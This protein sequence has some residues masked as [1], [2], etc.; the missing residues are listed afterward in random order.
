M[1]SSPGAGLIRR[2]RACQPLDNPRSDAKNRT[3][4]FHPAEAV[5]GDFGH[6]CSPPGPTGNSRNMRRAAARHQAGERGRGLRETERWP[7]AAAPQ[8][9]KK[10]GNLGLRWPEASGRPVGTALVRWP[11]W[12]KWFCCSPCYA[13][14]AE[15]LLSAAAPVFRT[16]LP[17]GRKHRRG[18][19]TSVLL[20][21]HNLV[22]LGCFSQHLQ[23]VWG[24]NI[25]S[26]SSCCSEPPVQQRTGGL[27]G[28]ERL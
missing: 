17:G 11:V 25:W 9:R 23:P 15:A 22:L 8:T 19:L 12:R 16:M 2:F 13:G 26:R 5:Q 20:L 6:S 4:R 1:T 27:C 21:W 14:E 10:S 7:G 3:R 24:P 18:Y 28:S